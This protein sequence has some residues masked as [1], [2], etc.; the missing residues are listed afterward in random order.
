MLADTS[1][2]EQ[3]KTQKSCKVNRSITLSAQLILLTLFYM[4][5]DKNA[6]KPYH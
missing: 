6:W 3:R 5:M 1:G 4:N 2:T